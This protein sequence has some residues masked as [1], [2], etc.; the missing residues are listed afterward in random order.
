MLQPSA[1]TTRSTTFPWALPANATG[2]AKAATLVSNAAPP[3]SSSTNSPSGASTNSPRV[4]T[5]LP[6]LPPANSNRLGIRRMPGIG[7]KQSRLNR[8][9]D[10]IRPRGNKINLNNRVRFNNR[11]DLLQ[12]NKVNRNRGNRDVLSFNR[13]LSRPS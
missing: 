4:V 1:R 6:H 5:P 7:N 9:G 12:D 13:G 10:K 11:V 8:G 2:H 3:T